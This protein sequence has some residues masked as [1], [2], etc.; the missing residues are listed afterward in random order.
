MSFLVGYLFPV[1]LIINCPQFNIYHMLKGLHMKLFMAILMIAGVHFG[2][3]MIM[4]A[5]PQIAQTFNIS[6]SAS[7]QIIVLYFFAFGLSQ[8]FYGPLSDTYGRRKIFIIGQSVFVVGSA[9]TYFATTPS[10]LMVAR[11]LQGLGAGAPLIISRAML[12]DAYNGRDLSQAIASLSVAASVAVVVGPI[13]GGAITT[14]LGW[15]SV[16]GLLSA[17]LSFTLIIG[18]MML[19]RHSGSTEESATLGNIVGQYLSFSKNLS[20]LSLASQ[21]WLLTFLL[22]I[23]VT[24]LPFEIQGK[25]GLTAAQYGYY[26][27]LP[28]LGPIVG[29]VLVKMLLRV[30]SAQWLLMACSLLILLA[31]LI[32]TFAPLTIFN[33]MVAYGLFML[34]LGAMFPCVLQLIV[35]PYQKQAGAVNA[36]VGAIEMLV[37]S[38]LAILAGRWFVS[39]VDSL[40]LVFIAVFLLLVCCT[41]VQYQKHRSQNLSGQQTPA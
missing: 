40:G 23:T 5:L 28:S 27:M 16:F 37:F 32:F 9:L 8:L 19:T 22:L 34:A 15:Q 31:G 6:A 25:L 29:S 17:Y 10:D 21:K 7:Q 26:L 24:F 39:D 2:A 38:G 13:V 33:L 30:F 4:P 11:I 36:Y 12:S 3:H 14:W 41:G 18:L 20:L 1:A 35:V